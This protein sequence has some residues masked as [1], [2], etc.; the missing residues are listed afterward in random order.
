M[1]P[2]ESRIF[3]PVSPNF[4]CLLHG[5]IINRSCYKIMPKAGT[6]DTAAPKGAITLSIHI[7]GRFQEGHIYNI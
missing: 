4:T 6:P 2:I 5:V 3:H 7:Q 1:K